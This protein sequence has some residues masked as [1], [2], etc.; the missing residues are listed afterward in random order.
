METSRGRPS[1]FSRTSRAEPCAASP[2]GQADIGPAQV[3][4]QEVRGGGV[5]EAVSRAHR[6]LRV[7]RRR[8]ALPVGGV[9]EDCAR[10]YSILRGARRGPAMPGRGL[11]QVGGGCHLLLQGPRRRS[12]MP[13]LELL[14]LGARVH[15]F[16]HGSWRREALHRLWVLQVGHLYHPV[17]PVARRA[18]P[19]RPPRLRADRSGQL[20]AVHH[21]RRWAT[22][23]PDGGL[24]QELP[25]QH[26]L[27]HPARRRPAVHVPG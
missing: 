8:S 4:R 11:L 3:P 21:A 16:L 2:G 12:A 27:L 9:Q 13:A 10:V 20:V 25:G 6:V 1:G 7:S 14:A 24:L 5:P 17:L 18:A 15:F 23:L 26:A 22:L 19:V